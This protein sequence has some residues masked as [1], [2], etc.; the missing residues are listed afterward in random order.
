MAQLQ[1][2]SGLVLIGMGEWFLELS[3]PGHP[4]RLLR[5][6][7][8]SVHA[9]DNVAVRSAQGL[10]LL[11]MK[12]ASRGYGHE[13]GHNKGGGHPRG[14]TDALG[15]GAAPAE[16]QIVVVLGCLPPW[17]SHDR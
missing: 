8:Y 10:S 2:P 17:R 9:Q 3:R 16:K 5:A 11:Q 4:H 15:P 6:L 7:L 12:M 14:R 1:Q 13:G